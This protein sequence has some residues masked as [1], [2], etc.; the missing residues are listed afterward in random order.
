MKLPTPLL[1]NRILVGFSHV[2]RLQDT[3]SWTTK[4]FCSLSVHP[5]NK[6]MGRPQILGRRGAAW[7]SYA[8][9]DLSAPLAYQSP[10]TLLSLLKSSL[11]PIR[12]Q[13][14]F[15]FPSSWCE[16]PTPVSFTYS[17]DILHQTLSIDEM[18]YIFHKKTGSNNHLLVSA[19]F[20]YT[21]FVN[22]YSVFTISSRP[23]CL[24]H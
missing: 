3:I 7:A 23:Y 17:V 15:T 16:T 2:A 10:V 5:S 11:K 12:Q 19:E 4:Q 20:A 1:F 18:L 6:K 9:T 24:W 22:L 13:K 14:H 21:D 8:P